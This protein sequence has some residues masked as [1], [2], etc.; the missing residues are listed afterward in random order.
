MKESKLDKL[1]ETKREKVLR[2]LSSE[3]LFI[4][5]TYKLTLT[6]WHEQYRVYE[7]LLSYG[8]ESYSLKYALKNV[9]VKTRT[10][11]E[12]EKLSELR[13]KLVKVSKL[14]KVLN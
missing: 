4:L 7:L 12:E 6:K 2:A 14:S 9:E 1:S 10:S 8:F 11:E 3:A 13:N 5:N